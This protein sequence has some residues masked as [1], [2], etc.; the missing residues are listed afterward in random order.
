[1]EIKNNPIKF[2]QEIPVPK[3]T[4]IAGYAAI[5]LFFG[6]SVPVRTPACI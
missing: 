5:V 1:M 4:T 2:F 6:I 3:D